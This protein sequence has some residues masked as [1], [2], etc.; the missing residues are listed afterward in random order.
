MPGIAYNGRFKAKIRKEGWWICLGTF[1]TH[2]RA[3][4]A[5]LLA[6]YWYKNG[7]ALFDIPRTARTKEAI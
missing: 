4:L 6:R 7:V 2:R 5:E 3:E 1:D